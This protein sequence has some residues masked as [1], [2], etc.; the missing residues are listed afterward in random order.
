[1]SSSG[2][3][4]QAWR[5]GHSR[6]GPTS[7][8]FRGGKPF[9][10]QRSGAFAR[11][12]ELDALPSPTGPILLKIGQ[13]DIVDSSSEDVGSSKITDLNYAVSY[14]W[15]DKD[16]PTIKV[17]GRPPTWTPL[18]KPVKLSQDSGTYY[19]DLNAAHYPKFPM[20]PAAQALLKEQP[21]FLCKDV[22]V[23][24]CGST[25]GNILRFV[26]KTEKT[27]RFVVEA[28]GDTVFFIR[29]EKSPRETIPNVRGYGHSFP[30]AYTTWECDVKGSTSHQRVISYRFGDLHLLLRFESDGYLRNL[31][32]LPGKASDLD[33]SKSFGQGSKETDPDNL[34]SLLETTAM[35]QRFRDSQ[36][37]LEIISGNES[38]IPQDALFDL[39]TR[40]A[41]RKGEDTL[42]EELPRLWISQI[43]NFILAYHD[44][45]VF[46]DIQVTNV[47]EEVLKWEREN[48]DTLQ[49]FAV[50]L[51]KLIEVARSMPGEVIEVRRAESDTLELREYAEEVPPLALPPKLE[52]R[53]LGE[54]IAP[55]SP[56]DE[57]KGRGLEEDDL[58]YAAGGGVMIGSDEDWYQSEESEKDYT[59]CSAEDCGYCGHCSY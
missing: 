56:L 39:K 7:G 55:Q 29:K 59:A 32:K 45:G 27:F 3:S 21:E 48:Q 4:S 16:G 51:R 54:S 34:S 12:P 9:P 18:A 28:V 35:Q 13:R 26:R 6:G 36:D 20:E 17:P 30:E 2:R 37:A 11:Q 44:Y 49:Q 24:A 53:W 1:M 52:A 14:N 22:D 43:P 46:E 8:T 31:T 15:L 25:L 38:I 23:V 41:Y 42:A 58:D 57:D 47:R 50:L 5:G 33:R 40:A 10:G 19:R